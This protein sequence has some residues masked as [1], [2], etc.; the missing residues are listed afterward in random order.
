MNDRQKLFSDCRVATLC[1]GSMCVTSSGKAGVSAPIVGNDLC[2]WH[3]DTFHE[4][5]ERCST[6]VRHNGQPDA[7]SVTPALSLVK[8]GA[9]LALTHLDGTGHNHLIVNA[10]PLAARTPTNQRF[11]NLDMFSM[12]PA[13]PILIG[14]HHASTKLVENLESRF[15]AR[16]AQLSL[17]LNGRHTLRLTGD[18]I[19]RPEPCTQR[20]MGLLH[21]S[22]G[23]QPSITLTL[24]A[25]KNA[26]TI[27][28]SVRLSRCLT[29][30]ADKPFAPSG[31]LQISSTGRFVRKHPLKL[32]QR[33]RKRKVISLQNV[34]YHCCLPQLIQMSDI[35]PLVGLG[36]NR[37]STLIST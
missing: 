13:N 23:R 19:R 18:Q 20:R 1:N 10:A 30:G 27:G 7:P 25:T 5:T 17:E 29:V 8:A 37:I 34:H 36:A 6:P 22:S 14:S 21:N 9:M 33:L 11:I 32:R 4:P 16:K 3:D 12:R 24:A 15:V 35:L 31:F 28:E 2:L 26:R